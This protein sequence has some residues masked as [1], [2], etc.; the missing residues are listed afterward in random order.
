MTLVFSM[1]IISNQPKTCILGIHLELQS[2]LKVGG[3]TIP[4][5]AWLYILLE[6]K[7]PYYLYIFNFVYTLISKNISSKP[8]KIM[9]IF[10]LLHQV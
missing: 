3:V 8:L 4:E 2:Q 9:L 5:K 6:V 7:L 1:S 10:L